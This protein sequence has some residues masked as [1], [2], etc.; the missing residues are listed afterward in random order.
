MT[1]EDA[2]KLGY[3]HAN[4]PASCR[5]IIMFSANTPPEVRREYLRGQVDGHAAWKARWSEMKETPC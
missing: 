2:Y 1:Q 3:D 4:R 5:G